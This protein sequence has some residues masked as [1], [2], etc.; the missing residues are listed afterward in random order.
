[1]TH[2]SYSTSQP[3]E[4]NELIQKSGALFS[5]GGWQGLLEQSFGCRTIYVCNKVTGFA[6][7]VFRA[8]PFKIGYLGFPVGGDIWGDTPESVLADIL[9]NARMRGMPI[10]IRVPV[11]AFS[12]Q[13]SLDLPYQS[14]PETVIENLQDWKIESIS[15]NLR[16]DIR[17]ADRSGFVVSEATDSRVGDTLFSIY[18]QTVKRHGGAIRYNAEY[19]R[20]LI[21]LAKVQPRLQVLIAT[22]ETDVAGFVVTARHG[23]TAYYLHGGA[24]PDYRRS[25]PSDL[26]LNE[27]IHRAQREGTQNFNLMASPPDQASLIRYKEKWGGV[28]RDLKT[29]TA[30]VRP[31][32]FLFRA[33]EKVYAL[34]R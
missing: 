3:D 7:S 11:S 12:Q 2:F 33:I 20:E 9:A 19:F 13:A 29:Y 21:K 24:N 17:K 32:Y 1:M 34:V 6:I 14:N 28:T 10:C 27:A 8:G 16:R 18:F 5:T 31:T 30:P 15:K 22:Q 4:W 23:N 25:S 26:L